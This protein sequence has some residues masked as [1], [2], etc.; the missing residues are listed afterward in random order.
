MGVTYVILTNKV[1]DLQGTE[2]LVDPPH[3]TLQEDDF[4]QADSE[5]AQVAWEGVEVVEVMKLH[6]VGEVQGHVAEN[7]ALVGEF[8]ENGRCNKLRG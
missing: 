2:T 5:T 4:R 3:E 1:E 7:G 8:V 6:G